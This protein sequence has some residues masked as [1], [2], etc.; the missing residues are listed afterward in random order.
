[1]ST[2]L[3]A[4]LSDYV[5]NRFARSDAQQAMIDIKEHMK[6]STYAIMS[7]QSLMEEIVNTRFSPG[8]QKAYDF[9]IDYCNRFKQYNK[10]QRRPEMR[11][12]KFQMRTYLQTA[13]SNIKVFQDISNRETD[14]LVMGQ[15]E[16]SW[17]EYLTNVKSTATRFD[18]KR[19][20]KHGRDINLHE[21]DQVDEPEEDTEHGYDINELKQGRRD[22]KQFAAQM[23][24]KTWNSL[25]QKTQKTWDEIDKDDKAKILEYTKDREARRQASTKINTHQAGSPSE[26]QVNTHEIADDEELDDKEESEEEKPQIN[27]NTLQRARRDAHAGDPRRVLGSD[28]EQQ[29][30]AMMHRLVFD[31]DS[32]DSDDDAS[33]DSYWASQD[34]H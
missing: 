9:V 25:S 27:V 11:I 17:E 13:L 6:N 29:I 19:G 5:D 15:P 18:A 7:T 2:V 12:N 22:S 20:N 1:M 10:Q 14:R 34:F 31:G 26:L 8:K 21:S 32:D 3:P 33:D 23:N 16:F 28:K 4:E 24:K 30:K